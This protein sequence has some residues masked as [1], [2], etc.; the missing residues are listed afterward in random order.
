MP[1]S[2]NNFF[3][4]LPNISMGNGNP[5]TWNKVADWIS[6]PAPNRLIMGGT[7]YL[8]QPYID[9]HN[10]RVKE[11]TRSISKDRTRAK[12]IIGT[13]AGIGV[14]QP[15]YNLV[16]LMTR[17]E[18]NKSYSRLLIPNSKLHGL[19][20]GSLFL[21]N[22]RTALSTLLALGVMVFTNFAVDAPLTAILTNRFIA[23]TKAREQKKEG[24][25]V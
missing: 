8:T 21:K 6:R 19:K 11:E 3:N 7:A 9:G 20:E 4:H 1:I 2:F 22:Y 16:E 18:G 10:K 23:K 5:E 13:L 15:S 25:N 17:P 24:I 12:V 14:R